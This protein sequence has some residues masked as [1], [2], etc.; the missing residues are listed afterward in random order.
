MSYNNCFILR[1][2]K[3]CTHTHIHIHK[4]L[5]FD[6][7]T[8][9]GPLVR[10]HCEVLVHGLTESLTI[11]LRIDNCWKCLPGCLFEKHFHSFVQCKCTDVVYR[12]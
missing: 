2:L 8:Q 11:K 7:S 5:V 6:I 4:E 9:S 10:D 3:T 1:E 12:G